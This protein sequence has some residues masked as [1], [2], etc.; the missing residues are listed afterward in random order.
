MSKSKPDKAAPAAKADAPQ[1]APTET[2]ELPEK[3]AKGGSYVRDTDG[4]LTRV[5]HTAEK[6]A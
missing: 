3:P 2:P 1:S 4:T 6:E 5:E